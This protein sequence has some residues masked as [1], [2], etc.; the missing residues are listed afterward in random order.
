MMGGLKRRIAASSL[1]IPNFSSL[2]KSFMISEKFPKIL[3]LY[4]AIFRLLSKT[5]INEFM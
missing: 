5:K 3:A 4:Y 2:I 1:S